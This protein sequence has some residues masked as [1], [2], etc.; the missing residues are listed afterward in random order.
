MER[1]GHCWRFSPLS[2]R[3]L[4]EE[5]FAP[6]AVEVEA[7]G[8]VLAACCLLHGI[9]AEE[10]TREEL[11]HHDPFYDVL[12]GVKAVRSRGAASETG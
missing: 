6:E 11:D 7:Y 10:L 1:W 4:F 5:F 3:R 9:L 2:A 12:I 8:N